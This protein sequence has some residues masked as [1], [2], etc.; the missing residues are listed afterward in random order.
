MSFR[1]LQLDPKLSF[2]LFSFCN[3]LVVLNI[4]YYSTEAFLVISMQPMP[5]AKAFKHQK[6]QLA[7]TSSVGKR[8]IKPQK[9]TLGL[10]VSNL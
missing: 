8:G 1:H 6:L 5:R 9:A 2:L 7:Y 10:I 3:D 4:R